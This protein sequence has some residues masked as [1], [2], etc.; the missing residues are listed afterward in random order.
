MNYYTQI[1][2]GASEQR[3]LTNL[4]ITRSTTN[5]T[6]LSSY[7]GNITNYNSRVERTGNVVICYLDFLCTKNANDVTQI[8]TIPDGYR[9]RNEINVNVLAN[10]GTENPYVRIDSAGKVYLTGYNANIS[11]GIRAAIPYINTRL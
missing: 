2:I 3:I 11:K 8:G 10:A 1:G 7:S 9:P 4:D 5:V 6:F